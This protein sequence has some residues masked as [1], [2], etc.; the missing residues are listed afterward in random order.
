MKLKILDVLLKLYF[1]L[2]S[3]MYKKYLIGGYIQLIYYSYK[4]EKI[5]VSQ[6]K[7]FEKPIEIYCNISK[8]LKNKL[9]YIITIGLI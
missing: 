4:L 7:I 8:Y 1:N 6:F 3:I 5:I 2:T 9:H